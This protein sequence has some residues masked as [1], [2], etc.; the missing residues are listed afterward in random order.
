M[1]IFY[2]LLA[3]ISMPQS[4]A[5]DL[6]S[7]QTHSS[8][9]HENYQLTEFFYHHNQTAISYPQLSGMKD[10]SKKEKLNKNIKTDALTVL[11]YYPD[12]AMTDGLTL[13]IKHTIKR[14]D[15]ELLSI[16]YDGLGNVSGTA[17][18]SNHFYTS[19]YLLT[20][21]ERVK[22][23]QLVTLNEAFSETLK[24]KSKALSPAMEGYLDGFSNQDLLAKLQTADQLERIGEND[25][26]DVFSYWTK[27]S[28]GISIGV[29]HAQ[30]DHAEF[31]VLKKEIVPFL[32]KPIAE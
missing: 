14:M 21:G 10:S 12:G 23:D 11:H 30:G 25:Q 20:H 3:C 28:L 7:L 15:R 2:I 29:S 13:D 17:H 9:T 8:N 6:N 24:K 32:K 1:I 16:Q 5:G 19:T 4:I 18:P 31:E 22:L 26:S 27:D